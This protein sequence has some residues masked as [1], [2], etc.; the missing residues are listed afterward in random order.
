M[1]LFE[2]SKMGKKQELTEAEATFCIFMS[3]IYAD[4]KMS[5]AE[6]NEFSYFFSKIKIFKNLTITDLFP[7]FQRIFK[8]LD[9][10]S[11]K[12]I[13]M[14]SQFITTNNRLPVYIYCCEIVFTD[15]SEKKNEEF[16]LEK[17]MEV[18]TLDE[19]LAENVINIM[20]RRSQL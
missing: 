15:E 9:Y 16:L 2:K 14:A 18:L 19:K 12:V 10:N 8:E 4:G 17:L 5:D 13:E 7:G 3:M 1:S 20:R 11:E 6:I